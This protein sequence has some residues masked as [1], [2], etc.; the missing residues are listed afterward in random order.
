MKV[1]E[2]LI[3]VFINVLKTKYLTERKREHHH[4]LI[5]MLLFRCEHGISLYIMLI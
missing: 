4:Q 3:K 2:V 1:H 5:D